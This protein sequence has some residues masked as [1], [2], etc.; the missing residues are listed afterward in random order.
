MTEPV[1]QPAPKMV[2]LCSTHIWG[3]THDMERVICINCECSPLSWEA[4]EPCKYGEFTYLRG[5]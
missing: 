1:S 4:K 3:N 2:P 5:D